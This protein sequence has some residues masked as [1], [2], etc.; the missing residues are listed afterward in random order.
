MKAYTNS[1]TLKNISTAFDVLWRHNHTKYAFFSVNI[2]VEG[3]AHFFG[4]VI[5]FTWTGM[6]LM[7]FG[8]IKMNLKKKFENFEKNR[9]APQKTDLTPKNYIFFDF[10]GENSVFFKIFLDCS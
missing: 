5:K 10:S 6:I 9:N 7:C 4:H 8:F 1:H 3:T 2:G